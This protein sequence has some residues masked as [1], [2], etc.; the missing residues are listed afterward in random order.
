MEKNTKLLIGALVVLL[1][2]A[3]LFKGQIQVEKRGIQMYTEAYWI[4]DVE[5]ES[6]LQIENLKSC[7]DKWGYP[8]YYYRLDLPPKVYCFFAYSESVVEVINI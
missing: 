2:T 4:K 8:F 7:L 3:I 6:N 1:V 5:G